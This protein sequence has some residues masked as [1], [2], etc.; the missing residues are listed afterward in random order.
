MSLQAQPFYTI[1]TTTGEDLAGAVVQFSYEDSVEEDDM[2]A[3]TVSLSGVD[4]ADA[5]EWSQGRQ[6]RVQ[7]GLSGKNSSETRLVE[8]TDVQTKYGSGGVRLSVKALDRGQ[9]AK[10]STASKIWKG[11]KA[12]DIAGEIAEGMGLAATL[13]PTEKVYES[14][15]QSNRSDYDFLAWLASKENR[16]FYIRSNTLFFTRRDLGKASRVTYA[17]G[18]AP[19]MSLSV[20]MKDT[21]SKGD[22]GETTVQGYDKDNNKPVTAKVNAETSE[23]ARLGDNEVAYDANAN[24]LPGQ[25][26]QEGDQKRRTGKVVVSG[27]GSESEASREAQKRQSDAALKKLTARLEIEG[28]PAINA[29][30]TITIQGVARRHGGN[31][32][33]AKATHQIS[34]GSGYTT[35][36]ELQKNATLAPATEG[37]GNAADSA[38]GAGGQGVNKTEG[39]NEAE[40]TK[41]LVEYDQ[42]A[43]RQK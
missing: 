12:S 40:Q 35:M 22:A 14:L 24:R 33:V 10:K 34:S 5:A 20:S 36:L 31:W 7:W 30:D 1:E 16:Q 8:V 13:E 21:D 43:I 17:Y 37:A 4:A 41:Q 18:E 11:K 26:R 6:F 3:L 2:L 39:P 25:E 27:T 29:G 15:P 38:G 42:D 9:A 28:D 32:Y 23:E 19:F